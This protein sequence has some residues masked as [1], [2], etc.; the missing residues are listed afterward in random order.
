[1]W[2]KKTLVDT[3]WASRY[4]L[5]E[6]EGERL[7]GA[8]PSSSPCSIRALWILS[9]QDNV[10]FSRRFPV[11][12]KRWRLACARENERSESVGYSVQPLLPTDPELVSA[13]S[14][15]KR[16]EGSAQ[17]FGI[18]LA[19]STQGSD[20]WVDD[21]ITRHIISLSI[22][23]E[24]SEEEFR[25]WP[26][27]LHTKGSYY[28]IVL[29]FVEPQQFKAYEKLC[30]RSD[31][32]GS[33]GEEYSLSS[34]LYNLPCIT[35]A[36]MVAHIVGDI[37]TGDV[38]DPDVVISS[39]PS[40]GGLLDSL[41]GSIGISARA[42][43]VAASVAASSTSGASAVGTIAVDASKS[44][45]RPIDKDTLLTFLSS[46]MP[47][48]T[49]LDLD[50]AHASVIKAH[51]FSSSDLPPAELKQPAWKPYLHKGK[52]RML[53]MIHETINAAMYDRDE[54]PDS[55]SI[56]GQVNCRAD[57]EGLPDVSLPL[58]G[59]KNASMEIVSFHHC[60]QVSEHS[61][62]K[63]ALMFSPPLGNFV[64]MHYQALCGPDPPVN[65]F[66]QLS[67]VSEDEGA[68]LFKLQLME[69][70]RAPFS[71][72]F[73]T[74]SMPFPRRRVLSFDGNPSTGTVS[75][76][77]HSL[78]W[79]IVTSG[80]GIT[81]K[82]IEATFPGTIKFFSRTIQRGPSL[83]RSVSRNMVEEDTHSDSEQDTTNNTLNIE[84]NLM[85]KMNKDLEPVDLE[86]PFCWQA[87]NYAKVSFKI[88]GGTLSGM[89]IDPKLVSIYPALKAPVELSM[90][91][92]SGEYILWNTLGKCPS[93][94][95][96][97]VY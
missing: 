46:S 85:E 48:G 93:A 5:P 88:I 39:S 29:P 94:V 60:V 69:G 82:S 50:F 63:Q 37:I 58:S 61:D 53:F 17:G 15:R 51:G 8:M 83:P 42:K 96:P 32:G 4:S 43:P 78:E 10:A 72:D 24:G 71:M 59:L 62:D 84:D 91:A 74:V 11:V 20:S 67:M 57:L 9:S 87:Y 36:I 66:Y 16:R 41:T 97:K 45:S 55:I 7:S 12:E 73:C 23:R 75:M 95:S 49:P 1:M 70:Y 86:E 68:F 76:T 31:C 3:I 44:T 14:E 40:V 6:G 25:L 89:S 65:G 79:K 30:T 28:I 22:K 18:R 34:L 92:S 2:K 64:L 81:G 35:G 26:L 56:T 52:Q 33:V 90:Q 47:F 54:I 21:P 80:R 38:V 13:F 19:Q 77:E 27:V